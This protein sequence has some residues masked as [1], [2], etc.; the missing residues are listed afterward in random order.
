MRA[1]SEES[2]DLAASEGEDVAESG[3]STLLGASSCR[4]KCFIHSDRI[5]H[6]D[7]APAVEFDLPSSSVTTTSATA[8]FDTAHRKPNHHFE[9]VG[10][11]EPTDP[12]EA[13]DRKCQ[14]NKKNRLI[15]KNQL[16]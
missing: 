5:H 4:P 15:R 13:A 7:E 14:L 9:S 8:D 16:I 12:E 1:E 10:V 6:P 11:D 2:D 3:S